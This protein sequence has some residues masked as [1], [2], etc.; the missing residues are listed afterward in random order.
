MAKKK[1]IKKNPVFKPFSRSD[2]FDFID[3]DSAC[4]SE[5]KSIDTMDKYDLEE[6]RDRLVEA[7]FD[8]DEIIN[9]ELRS[10]VL[11]PNNV[12]LADVRRRRQQYTV[13]LREVRKRIKMMENKITKEKS[14]VA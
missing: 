12:G 1:H 6:I 9:I 7:I 13:E 14:L 3:N 8:C 5:E 4:R 10:A 11:C 2:G